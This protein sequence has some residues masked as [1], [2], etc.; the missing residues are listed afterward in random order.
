M[1][2]LSIQSL[3]CHTLFWRTENA[4]KKDFKKLTNDDLIEGKRIILFDG[5]VLVHNSR[6]IF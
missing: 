5:S 4:P 1:L 3:K 2:K 6:I